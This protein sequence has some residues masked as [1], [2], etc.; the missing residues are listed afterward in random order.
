MTSTRLYPGMRDGSL[1]LFYV[2]EEQKLMAINAGKILDYDQ[3][4]LAETKFL[5]QIIDAE[6]ET[7]E[8]LEKWYP[9]R[10]LQKKKLAECRFG[11]LNFT[12]DF[13]NGVHAADTFDCPLKCT[14]IGFGKVC[15]NLEYN[16]HSL[17]S[18]D[19]KAISL[20]ISAKKNTVIAEELNIPLGSF[21]VYR[22]RLYNSLKISTKQELA[23]VAFILGLI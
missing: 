2:K 17:D 21:E 23:S 18:F 16:G 19:E 9:M 10:A 15:R 13:T 12:P 11:G 1:E 5:D 3:L 8:I 20:L 7:K 14:C 4:S 22:T 6:N